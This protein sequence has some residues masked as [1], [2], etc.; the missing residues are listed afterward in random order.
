[1]AVG[2]I[3]AVAAIGT[4]QQAVMTQQQSAQVQSV[5]QYQSPFLVSTQPP[6]LATA[7][8]A[9]QPAMTQQ[10]QYIPVQPIQAY[11]LPSPQ[12]LNLA[13]PAAPQPM[14]NSQY[15]AQMLPPVNSQAL[16]TNSGPIQ[17]FA[18]QPVP[19]QPV[20]P[21]VPGQMPQSATN[22]APLATNGPSCP[23]SNAA[24]ACNACPQNNCQT[25]APSCCQQP[26][27]PPGRFWASGEYLLWWCE[28]SATPAL[29]TSSPIG[30]PRNQFGVL[31]QP[32]TTVVFGNEHLSD[33]TRNGFR[34]RF[35]GWLDDCHTCGLEA[36]YFLL[37][38]VKHDQTIG[39]LL[40]RPFNNVGTGQPD[41]ELINFPGVVDGFAQILNSNRFTGF[42]INF[43]KCCRCD[44][45]S[46]CDFLVGFRYL[47]LEDELYVREAL[48][49]TGT[50]PTLNPPPGTRIVLDDQFETRNEFYGPQFGL[51]GEFRRGCMF[52][53]YRGMIAIGTT[54][55]A[56]TIDGET[57]ITPPGP[58]A[59]PTTYNGGLYALPTNIGHYT[60]NDF[61]VVPE[62][63]LNVGY[64]ITDHIRAFVGYSFIYWSD[65]TRP[66]DVIDANINTS[67][68]PPGTLVGPARPAF[69]WHHSDFWAHG[70]NF[71]LEVRY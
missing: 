31:G 25:C 71:G 30:T 4:A 53:N 61:S 67:Q 55:K 47:S 39:G 38:N 28:G 19:S 44:C 46:R 50:D 42:D 56:V 36:S 70:V 54:H 43:R 66:G 8:V 49:V 45:C 18:V 29:L 22:A 32:N 10:M 62:L 37:D 51:A 16:I 63:N 33:D 11:T 15:N 21:T 35:G 34:I 13:L 3:L 59:Q 69:T 27:G 23:A 20:R 12:S 68:L 9:A 7:Q 60:R 6:P 57:M 58:G 52:V 26:C 5:P 14:P 48:V 24:N 41:S 2:G 17:Y 64:Q 65:V 40:A 1:M